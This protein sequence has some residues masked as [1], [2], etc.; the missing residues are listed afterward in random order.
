MTNASSREATAGV[1][2]QRGAVLQSVAAVV[3]SSSTMLP[4]TELLDA[5]CTCPLRLPSVSL[6][7]MHWVTVVPGETPLV[8]ETALLPSVGSWLSSFSAVFVS[9][10]E[11]PTTSVTVTEMGAL[12]GLMTDPNATSVPAEF[13]T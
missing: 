1:V 6:G 10:E 8:G 12:G 11:F 5:S 9:R 3:L 7:Q 2:P 4:M 13:T